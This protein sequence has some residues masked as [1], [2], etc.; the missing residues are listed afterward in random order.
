MAA[1][2]VSKSKSKSNTKKKVISPVKPASELPP[3]TP[4]FKKKYDDN[5]K[6]L[7]KFIKLCVDKFEKYI[8]SISILPPLPKAP[9]MPGMPPAPIPSPNEIPLFVLIDDGDVKQ[10]SRSEL[11]V[12][13]TDITNKFAKELD[14][15]FKPQVMLISELKDACYDSKADVIKTVA[16]S[17][18]LYDKGLLQA[19]KLTQVHKDMILKKFEKYVVSYIAAGSFF[20]GDSNPADIDVFI[21]I[22]DT[23]VKKM[24]RLELRDRLRGIIYQYGH[25]ASRITGVKGDFHI[26]NYILTDFWD[27]VKE[28]N[29]VIFTVLRDG[30]PIY[31]RGVFMPWKLLL[32]MGRIKPSPEA[33]DMNM[34]VGDKLLDSTKQKLLNVVGQDLFYAVMNPTQAALM[35][36]GV[37]PPTPR[38]AVKLMEEIYVKKEK[39]LEQKYV[40]I[41]ENIRKTFKEIEHKTLTEVSGKDVDNLIKDCRA[42]LERIKKLFATIQERNEKETIA[43]IHSTSLN[44]TKDLLQELGVKN[45]SVAKT[46]DLFKK[47]VC[48]AEKVPIKYHKSLK[49]IIQA[50]KDFLAKKL[51]KQEINKVRREANDYIRLILEMLDS[52]RASV[53]NKSKIYFKKDKVYGELLMLEKVA[54]LTN[55][56]TKREEIMIGTISKDGILINLKKSK[57]AEYEKYIKAAKLPKERLIKPHFFEALKELIGEGVEIIWKA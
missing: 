37:P 38:E 12:K 28:A 31:D 16:S 19:L 51:S 35:L 42:Y 40:D 7:D 13:M 43:E 57:L 1:K 11:I 26:Q 32:Q 10:M 33:I 36:Y 21:V 4:E 39:M 53:L 15:N 34:E 55:D 47:H 56:I 6:N 18:I 50:R 20:R 46:P 24:S 22:D 25:E 54:F 9:N 44:L 30:V 14:P 23:D 3:L 48:E 27:W 49:N 8:T 17:G 2:K 29:P 5:K 45:I 52:R 41:L